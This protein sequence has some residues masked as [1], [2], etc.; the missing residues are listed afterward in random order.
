MTIVAA[1]ITIIALTY[2]MLLEGPAWLNRFYSLFAPT[3][4][5]RLRG[6]FE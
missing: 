1:V 5:P 3:T 2:F 6:I 4:E